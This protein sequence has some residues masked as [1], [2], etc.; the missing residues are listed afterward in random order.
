MRTAA[1]VLLGSGSFFRYLGHWPGQGRATWYLDTWCGALLLCSVVSVFGILVF[2]VEFY[3]LPSAEGS[4][5]YVIR[6]LPGFF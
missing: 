3:P 2:S 5:S 6:K 4:Q 1:A